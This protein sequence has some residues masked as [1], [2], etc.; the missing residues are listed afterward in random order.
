MSND[1][2]FA[3]VVG[4]NRYP[5]VERQLTTARQDAEA[6]AGWL[7]DPNKGGLPKDN[8][9]GSGSPRSQESSFIDSIDAKPVRD[10]VINSLRRF[11]RSVKGLNDK[12]WLQTRLYI[13]A[14]GHGLVPPDGRGA[15]LF[16][17]FDPDPDG[18]YAEYLDLGK[19]NELYE[20]YT[21]FS[22]VLLLADCCRERKEGMPIVSS[23]P[24]FGKVRG[25]TKRVLGYAT[26]Y[27]RMA[28]A[29]ISVKSQARGFFTK[30]LL[31]GLEGKADCDPRTGIIDSDQLRKYIR[32][33]VPQLAAAVG[34]KQRADFTP[35]EIPI[36]LARRDVPKF[37]VT[38]RLPDGWRGDVALVTQPEGAEITV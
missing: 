10:D 35:S 31:E 29:D 33:R 16:A 9:R 15:L 37:E 12:E 2:H 22:E 38:V 1:L 18:G 11:H 14:A 19:Y 6:F 34:Y 25:A 23:L 28:G 17:N 32:K 27:S 21:P 7:K 30:A 8:V 4:I 36:S 5:G 26:Q 13:Y 20:K 24:F 3:I